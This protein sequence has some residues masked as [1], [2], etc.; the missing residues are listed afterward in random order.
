MLCLLILAFIL[1]LI[2]IWVVHPIIALVMSLISLVV[3]FGSTINSLLLFPLGSMFS[4]LVGSM[5]L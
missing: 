3:Y 1:T 2:I 5:G 4:E